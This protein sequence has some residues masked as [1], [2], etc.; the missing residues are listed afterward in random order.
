M[1]CLNITM[2]DEVIVETTENINQ[3]ISDKKQFK[4]SEQ[5]NIN[6]EEWNL[7]SS[8]NIPFTK[9]EYGGTPKFLG[10]SNGWT[11]YYIG[12]S[13]LVSDNQ[14]INEK[15]DKSLVVTPKME[16]IDFVGMLLTAFRFEKAAKYF[17]HYYDIDFD[18]PVKDADDDDGEEVF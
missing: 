15:T 6:E 16:N 14:K 13:W 8:L 3:V 7:F 4:Y 9:T 11:S 18:K 5:Q 17:S 10:I 1:E 2:S 12:A